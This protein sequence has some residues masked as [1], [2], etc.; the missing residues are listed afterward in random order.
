[1]GSLFCEQPLRKRGWAMES[2]HCTRCACT[3]CGAYGRPCHDHCQYNNRQLAL[4]DVSRNQPAAQAPGLPMPQSTNPYAASSH[5]PQPQIYQHI[6]HLEIQPPASA[7]WAGASPWPGV[8][9]QPVAAASSA[10]SEVS[11]PHEE[12]A[13]PGPTIAD[14]LALIE[15]LQ[16][17]LSI[18]EEELETSRQWS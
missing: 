3:G 16:R 11:V 10:W 13:A 4:A 1:M 18:V 12:Q 2:G 15:E 7:S 8:S 5:Q 17:R 14:L 6:E 9:D